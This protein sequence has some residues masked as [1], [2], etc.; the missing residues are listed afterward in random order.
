MVTPEEALKFSQTLLQY[1]ETDAGKKA[2]TMIADL[3]SQV[4]S[5]QADA[6][7]M[8]WIECQGDDFIT[9]V[10]HD[11]PAAGTYYV[12]GSWCTGEGKTFREA[13]DEARK[14]S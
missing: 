9:G 5:L 13:I 8:D 12:S 2:S 10:L 14:Q 4:E 7:R 11:C 3:A 1:C 6:E